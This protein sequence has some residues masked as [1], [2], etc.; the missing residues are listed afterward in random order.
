MDLNKNVHSQLKRKFRYS[1]SHHV[2]VIYPATK[3]VVYNDWTKHSIV[4]LLRY[5]PIVG[6]LPG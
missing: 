3:D 6:V 5:K 2:I 1:M 4:S